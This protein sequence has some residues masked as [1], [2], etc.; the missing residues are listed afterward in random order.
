MVKTRILIMGA[1]GRDFHNFN[2]YF[3]DNPAYEVVAYTATQIPNIEGRTYPPQLAGTLYPA[4][5]PIYPESELDTQ[6]RELDVDQVIFAYSDVPHEYVMHKASQVLA[7]GAG[8]RLMGAKETMLKAKVPVVSV[9]AVR[10][11]S[12]KSQTTRRTSDILRQMGKRLVVVRHP[13][14]YGD[15]VEQACQ[16]FASYEDL[17]KHKCTVEEREEYEPHLDR[18]TV[19]YAG[20][21]YQR[22]LRQAE[23]EA[24]VI[25]WDGGNND[26]PFYEPDLHIVVADPLRAGHELR[27]HPGEANLRMADVVVIN[28]IETAEPDK[29]A[30][31]RH[32]IAALN[33]QATVVDAASP[34]FLD[35][36]QAIKGATVL[37]IE[38][39]PTL[40]HGEMA[41]GAGFVAARRFG[42]AEIVDP[43]DYAVGSIAETYREYP[44]TGPVLPAMGYDARQIQ[45][46]EETINATPCDL[47]IVATPIDLRRVLQINRPSQR[48]RY[49]LQEIGRPDLQDVLSKQFA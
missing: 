19:V 44:N 26:L 4:G 33:P 2:V 30:M 31:V 48:V 16:R 5:I 14:P 6:I 10:T 39:G 49:E 24:E 25:L 15:L 27:Y 38:D 1:A 20:V 43:R 47:V 37:I 35:D 11:G 34:I 7:V 28:K 23:Q 21:D 17:D 3:R 29:V 41:Y 45:E 32:N 12:G 46:L 42:A 22:I 18:G 36:P 13:M 9:C 8:F 40:T